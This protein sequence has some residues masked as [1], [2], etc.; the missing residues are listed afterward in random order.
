MKAL[1]SIL[2]A[3][4]FVACAGQ[5]SEKSIRITQILDDE[6]QIEVGCD[7]LYRRIGMINIPLIFNLKSASIKPQRLDDVTYYFCTDLIEDIKNTYEGGWGN[8]FNDDEQYHLFTGTGDMPVVSIFKQARIP[9]FTRQFVDKSP[10]LQ[11]SLKVYLDEMRAAGVTRTQIGTLDEF[12]RQRPGLTDMLMHG[13]SIHF[14][15]R[16]K[17]TWNY[18]FQ[19]SVPVEY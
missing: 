4:A 15:F 12:K 10:I 5:N 11:D 7:S 6:R 1:F 13:D 18:L 3:T 16:D 19:T 17:N 14:V 9:L 2:I 8:V